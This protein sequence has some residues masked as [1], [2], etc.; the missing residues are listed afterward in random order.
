MWCFFIFLSLFCKASRAHYPG[1]IVVET[2][3]GKVRGSLRGSVAAFQG[4]RYAFPP[5]GA[6][7]FAA[8][9]IV[10]ISWGDEV[11]DATGFGAPCLQN[12]LQDVNEHP[13]PEA[14]PPDEDCLFANIYVPHAGKNGIV[15]RSHEE[16]LPVMVWVH[17]GGLCIG[18]SSSA[19]QNY[20]E[21]ARSEGVIVASF[22]YRL[23]A[24]GFMVL[25]RVTGFD[26]HS[27]SGN[28]G[29]NGIHDQIVAL[30]WLRRE[31]KRFG[32]DPD[33]ITIFGESAGGYSVCALIASPLAAGLFQRSVIQSG[34]CIGSW[35]P[36]NVSY[37]RD[38]STS[39]MQTLGA[40]TLEDLR[41]ANASLIQWPAEQMYNTS[42]APSF[43]GY[44]YDQ[45]T[46]PQSTEY[47]F[48][49]PDA[50]INGDSVII[51]HTSKD[52]TAAFYGIAP[53]L[54]N[55]TP[56]DLFKAFEFEW[57]R[58]LGPKVFAQYSLSRFNGSVQAAFVQADAD[59]DVI[60]PSYMIADLLPAH[61]GMSV[62]VF[63]FAHLRSH[64]CDAAVEMGV[65]AHGDTSLTQWASHGSDVPFTFGSTSGPDGLNATAVPWPPRVVCPMDTNEQ[66]LSAAMRRYWSNF[67]RTGDP[68]VHPSSADAL[69]LPRWQRYNVINKSTLMLRTKAG[70]GIVSVS[71]PRISKSDC[72]FWRSQ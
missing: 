54:D 58:T 57:G 45:N 26:V 47:Y 64:N 37:G 10:N 56:S 18:A 67:A 51:G 25:D 12:P 32:G 62:Y 9:Q 41:A 43:S 63:E 36:L 46:L 59:H 52:G 8:A 69:L 66:S 1:G 17:G 27:G 71:R 19:W 6:R 14:P 35:G 34:P 7:R 33:R 4:L 31:L 40:K 16:L 13:K 53:T 23:G 48:K 39:I 11:V 55:S 38:V 22:N 29:M 42:V 70:G 68:N 3:L 61:Q 44:F 30:K 5:L 20:T 50:Q 2:T 21:L 60:C 28:G 49:S 24:L 15:A 65:L 72:V